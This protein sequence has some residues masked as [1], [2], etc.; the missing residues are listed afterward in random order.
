M[1]GTR[2]SVWGLDAHNYQRHLLHAESSAWVEKNCYVDLWIEVLHAAKLEPLAMLP[3]T[4]ASDFD[5]EQWTFYKPPHGDLRSLYGVDVQEMTV[6]KPLIEHVLFHAGQGRLVMTEAD[7]YWLPDTRGTDYRS[8]H[9]KTTIAIDKINLDLRTLGYFHNAGYYE[10]EGED[11]IQLFRLDMPADPAFLPLFAELAS[12]RQ[13]NEGSALDLAERSRDLLQGWLRAAPTTNPLTRFGA[14]LTSEL[15]TLRAKGM[16]YY[17]AFAF[18][19]IRQCG[20]AFELA[21]AYLRWL[22]SHL[23]GG[24]GEAAEAFEAISTSAKS[25]I[26]KGARAVNS[27]KP[28]DFSPMFSEMTQNWDRGMSLIDRGK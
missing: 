10:L 1:S 26:L 15:E 14:H 7:A 21:A 25:L 28:V 3:F 6:F 5:G 9:T 20:S 19:T 11:F 24:Y 2:A 8:Q 22:E 16:A 23:P 17:H 18:A 27:T 4:L 13:T 12:F